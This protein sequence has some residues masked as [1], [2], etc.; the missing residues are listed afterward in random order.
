MKKKIIEGKTLTNLSFWSASKERKIAE[1]Y[2]ADPFRN[3][4]FNISSVK[5]NIDMEEMSKFNNEKEVLFLPYSKF[6]IKS[7]EKKIL[8][9]K[10]VYEV[11]L[12]GLDDENE[13]KDIKSFSVVNEFLDYLLK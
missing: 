11:Q 13:R 8:K 2:L 6:L 5:C 9:N 12:E 1:N 10:E 7:K 3:I 4:I